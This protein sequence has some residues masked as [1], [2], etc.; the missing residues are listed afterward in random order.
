MGDTQAT[1]DAIERRKRVG[2][3]WSAKL[4]AERRLFAEIEARLLA[5]AIL[6]NEAVPLAA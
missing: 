2:G 1:V 3:A 5:V 6:P 4:K